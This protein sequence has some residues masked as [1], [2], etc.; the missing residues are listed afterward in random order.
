MVAA[1]SCLQLSRSVSAILNMFTSSIDC[2][3]ALR[4]A[5]RSMAKLLAKRNFHPSG[6]APCSKLACD[7][8]QMDWIIECSESN[9]E[10][11]DSGFRL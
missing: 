6:E 1:R 4:T 8:L 7:K 2:L 5:M 11:A 10:I 9:W 3:H